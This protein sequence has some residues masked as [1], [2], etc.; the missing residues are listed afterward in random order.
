M[1]PEM[2]PDIRR[3]IDPRPPPPAFPE[4]PTPANPEIEPVQ[5]KIIAKTP[6]IPGVIPHIEA[7]GPGLRIIEAA[8]PGLVIKPGAIDYSGSK[9]EVIQIAGCVAGVDVI[10]AYVIDINVFDIIYGII[11]RDQVHFLRPRGTGRPGPEGTTGNKPN[12]VVH[13]VK[14]ITGSEHRG[15]RI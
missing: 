15:R 5:A 6:S 14:A 8:P 1:P 11:R 7:P 4:S 10:R 9:D 13:T 12:T 3:A 2:M